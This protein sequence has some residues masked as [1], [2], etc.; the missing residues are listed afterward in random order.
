MLDYPRLE[1]AL[2]NKVRDGKPCD[3]EVAG[4]HRNLDAQAEIIPLVSQ[5][6]AAF[7]TAYLTEKRELL[8][9]RKAEASDAW[10]KSMVEHSIASLSELSNLSLELKGASQP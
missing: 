5:N 9:K 8:N 1:V 7:L 2:I 10:A 4:L 3:G 6:R